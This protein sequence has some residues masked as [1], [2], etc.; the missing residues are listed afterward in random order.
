MWNSWHWRTVL[1]GITERFQYCFIL[2]LLV[3]KLK[4]DHSIIKTIKIGIKKPG[5]LF[6]Q[7]EN[8]YVIQR[9]LIYH[10]SEST[11]GISIIFLIVLAKT[12]IQIDCS[13]RKK[14]L[15]KCETSNL[16]S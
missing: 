6:S 5:Y 7:T 9:I 16:N 15:K 8:S 14:N 4:V 13:V 3:V 2:L 12:K 11:E 1:S 10:F